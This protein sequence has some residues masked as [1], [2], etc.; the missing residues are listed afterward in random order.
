MNHQILKSYIQQL[1]PLTDEATQ[2]II[3]DMNCVEYSKNELLLQESQVSKTMYFLEKGIIRSFLYDTDGNEITTNLFSAPCFVNDFLSFFKQQKTSEYFQ[4]L[5]PCVL[6]KMSFDDVQ[7]NF[8]SIPEFREFGR[9]ILVTSY[10]TLHERMIRQIKDSAE[11][12]Y[13]HLMKNHPD[14]F[15]HVPLKIIA[16]YLGITDTSLSRIRKEISQK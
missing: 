11:T 13:L 4:T 15:Q 14:I 6:W 10:S 16:S 5:S 1:L 7:R 2:H 8:H 3:N 12:R 9:M